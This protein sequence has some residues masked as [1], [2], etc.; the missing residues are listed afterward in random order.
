MKVARS[1]FVGLLIQSIKEEGLAMTGTNSTHQCL[2]TRSSDEI[3]DREIFQ[4]DTRIGIALSDL[5]S[6]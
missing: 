4:N 2:Q 1:L 5:G 6:A 3:A